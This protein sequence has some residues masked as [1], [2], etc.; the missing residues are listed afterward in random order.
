MNF[1]EFNQFPKIE[2]NKNIPKMHKKLNSCDCHE[3]MIDHNNRDHNINF[4]VDSYFKNKTASESRENIWN[5][6]QNYAPQMDY[7]QST[8]HNSLEN[9]HNTN[10]NMSKISSSPN[11]SGI[12]SNGSNS[13]ENNS[14]YYDNDFMTHKRNDCRDN[15][16]TSFKKVPSSLFMNENEPKGE[17]FADLEELKNSTNMDLWDYAKTQKGSRY[18]HSIYFHLEIY[19]SY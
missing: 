1:T 5:Q 17:D 14:T 2:G 6:A 15:Q 16:K 11:S 9:Y 10:Y 19:R 4:I 13:D 18:T 3:K 8:R 12:F 7:N